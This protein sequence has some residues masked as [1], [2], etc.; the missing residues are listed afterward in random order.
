VNNFLSKLTHFNS[1][2]PIYFLIAV[3]LVQTIL[4]SL[5]TLDKSKEFNTILFVHCETSRELLFLIAIQRHS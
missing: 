2:L 1:T 4:S 3:K 5:L